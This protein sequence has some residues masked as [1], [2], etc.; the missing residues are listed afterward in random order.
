MDTLQNYV[1]EY[2]GLARDGLLSGAWHYPVRGIYHFVR[3]PSLHRVIAPILL[4]LVSVSAGIT[5]AM[6]FFTYLP[7]VAFCAL[8]GPFAFLAAATMVLGESYALILLVSKTFFLESAQDKLFDAVLIQQG[9]EELVAQSRQIKARGT[10]SGF[11]IVGKSLTKPLNRFSKEGLIRYI[12]SIPLNSIP[13]AGTIIFL[14]Y[15]GIKSGPRYHAR[16]FQL[17]H[18][19]KKDRETSVNE[20]RGAY[21]ASVA[22]FLPLCESLISSSRF[23]AVALALELIPIVGLVFSFTSIV[24]AALWASDCEGASKRQPTAPAN[25]EVEIE[26]E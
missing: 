12:L 6:F 8:L 20:R 13:V 11:K 26:M 19:D 21:A 9:H 17:K 7:Q 15:N 10:S 25:S 4:R 24:G 3:Y 1:S 23:G 18:M 14:F 22:V 5:V 2:F 16:Y